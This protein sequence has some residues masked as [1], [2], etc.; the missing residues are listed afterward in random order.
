MCLQ[1]D[2]LP[3]A[4]RTLGL[5]ALAGLA[6]ACS[7]PP[8]P[9]LRPATEHLTSLAPAP[10][11]KDVGP[12]ADDET[13]PVPPGVACVIDGVEYSLDEY[14][15]YMLMLFQR[16][17]LDDFVNQRLLENEARELDLVPTDAEVAARV[18][19]DMQEMIVTRFSGDEALFA[20][21]IRRQGH[22]LE[23][24]RELFTWQVRRELM[25]KR[26]AIARR[27]ITDELVWRIFEREYGL[28]GLQ[29]E[30]RH[31]ILTR[32]REKMAMQREGLTGAELTP[33][34]IEQR[35]IERADAILVEYVEGQSFE[36]LARRYSHD[37]AA[38][39][40]G[41]TIEN[42]HFLRYGP[43]FADAVR[44][45]PVGEVQGPVVT[46][47][48]VHLF[49]VTKRVETKLEDVRA[50]IEEIARTEDPGAQEILLLEERLRA[51]ADVQTY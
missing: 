3:R 1:L 21:D 41:G 5:G 7:A 32:A 26:V 12:A 37:N 22:D 9:S 20:R 38:V 43:A 42:Y 27:E 48:A 40:T 36:D 16:R 44:A 33:E 19:R 39:R 30:V 49:E 34:R 8:G 24:Y 17:W 4:Q 15:D 35:L 6:W 46:P 11:A 29:V 51:E 14:R 23:S 13:A 10:Q 18:E 31:I 47:T 2:R 28:G 50:E 25:Q 45:A